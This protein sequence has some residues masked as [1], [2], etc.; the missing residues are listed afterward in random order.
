MVRTTITFLSKTDCGFQKN[1]KI[2]LFFS[3]YD[4]KLVEVKIKLVDNL[5]GW[6]TLSK[7]V[8]T[9]EEELFKLALGN[10][11]TELRHQHGITQEELADFMRIAVRSLSEIENGKCCPNS[12]ML[13]R[14]AEALNVDLKDV[15]NFMY[16]KWWTSLLKCLLACLFIGICFCKFNRE[17]DILLSTYERINRKI[18]IRQKWLICW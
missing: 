2:L 16:K 6:R 10:R 5:I 15:L 12:I 11:I 17:R 14:I 7:I 4:V 9:K 3:K 1:D 18:K 13:Y 8:Y